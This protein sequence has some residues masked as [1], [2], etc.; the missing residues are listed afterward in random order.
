MNWISQIAVDSFKAFRAILLI[1]SLGLVV[2]S[3]AF[4][5]KSS[6]VRNLRQQLA[7]EKMHRQTAEWNLAQLQAY[8]L[9]GSTFKV[10]SGGKSKYSVYTLTRQIDKV[11]DETYVEVSDL[12]DSD[13]QILKRSELV[14][15]SW[16]GEREE[17]DVKRLFYEDKY[18]PI[19]PYFHLLIVTSK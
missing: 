8:N 18:P 1:V 9:V 13:E 6:E 4:L 15:F 14:T 19:F 10:K 7:S 5:W 16:V 2:V 3:C 12:R 11:P 17:S